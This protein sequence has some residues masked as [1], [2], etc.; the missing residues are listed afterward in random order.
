VGFELAADGIV[1]KGFTIAES[2][3]DIDADGT[4]GIRTSAS[5]SGYTIEENVIQDN[6]VGIYLNTATTKSNGGEPDETEVEDNVIR[7]NNRTGTNTGNGIFSDLGLQNVEIKDN[8]FSGQN[9]DASIKIVAAGTEPN[10]TTLRSDIEIKKNDFDSL[11][12]AGIYFEEVVDSEIKK[13]DFQ[14]LG[15]SAIQLNGGNLRVTISRNDL[16]NVGTD[17]FDGI[18]LNNS[19]QLG[20][21]Q[22][23]VIEKNEIE[24]AGLSGIVIRDSA[25]NTIKK[26]KIKL[27]Q[28]GGLEDTTAGNGIS[29]E[30]ADNN[31]IKKNKVK[32]NARNGIFLDAQSTGNTVEDNKSKDNN[33]GDVG[34]F[35]YTDLSTGGD[36]PSGRQNEY[37]DNKGGT[38]NVTGLIDDFI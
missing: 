12:G 31:T 3:T 17:D 13:N 4:V 37:D 33:T 29:L 27:S 11:T 34:A 32:E 23:N 2:G 38:E 8:E 22:N 21:N 19:S 25:N 30:N 28:L 15:A 26:N 1:I 24:G 9:N 16:E 7:D 18:I 6:T 5:F 36:G 14:D 20:S 10:T 35:D